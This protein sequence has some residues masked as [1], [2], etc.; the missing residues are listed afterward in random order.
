[1]RL[2]DG[3]G[4]LATKLGYNPN[5]SSLGVDVTFLLFGLSSIA[6]LTP[7]ISA[8]LARGPKKAP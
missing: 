1:V 3:D 5:S 2:R 6:L 7:V 8:L 4:I